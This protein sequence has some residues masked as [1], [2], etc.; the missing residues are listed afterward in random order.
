M[1]RQQREEIKLREIAAFHQHQRIGQQDESANSVHRQLSFEE[2]AE[3]KQNSYSRNAS[4]F[5][6]SFEEIDI[7]SA[8]T[9]S[10]P[11]PGIRGKI[12]RDLSAEDNQQQPRRSRQR[13]RS[14]SS[15]MQTRRCSYE[16]E[17]NTRRPSYEQTLRSSFEM[18]PQPHSDPRQQGQRPH[19]NHVDS[20]RSYYSSSSNES[21]HK[22]VAQ[23]QESLRQMQQQQNSRFVERE[24]SIRD[25]RIPVRGPSES[26]FRGGSGIYPVPQRPN[27]VSSSSS[28][29]SGMEGASFRSQ[30]SFE[31]PPYGRSGVNGSG[32]GQWADYGYGDQQDYYD[33]PP[34]HNQRYQSP[35]PP[36]PPQQRYQPTPPPPPPVN[37]G[38]QIE[39][40]PGFFAELRGAEETM[41][42]IA[43]GH[44][45]SVECLCCC[46]ALQCIADA[47]YVL[48]PDCKVVSPI[49]NGIPGRG[50]VG[51]G[52]RAASSSSRG[53]G[54]SGPSQR[55]QSQSDPYY[56]SQHPQNY[57]D[58]GGGGRY[59]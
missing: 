35:L 47:E 41:A 58:Y 11:L 15:S 43:V 42:A 32:P 27:N 26:S 10:D 25:G 39:I 12:A 51:L 49:F 1:S 44:V 7:P 9:N 52:L 6:R 19:I 55:A 23:R 4:N 14:P 50:G 21:Q 30:G 3:P 29:Y 38:L 16:E 5:H 33:I 2:L 45:A 13:S 40:E 31:Q 18:Q 22:P 59:Y 28:R 34:S 8:L 56:H 48:C 20:G 54:A 53:G 57:P 24:N 36:P 37:E 17:Q 46:L